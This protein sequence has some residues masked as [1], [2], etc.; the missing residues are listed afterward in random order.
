[1]KTQFLVPQLIICAFA[2]ASCGGDKDQPAAPVAPNSPS[3]PSNPS[4]P[5]DPHPADPN[6]VAFSSLA[7][8]LSGTWVHKDEC[9]VRVW[10]DGSETSVKERVQIQ[11]TSV[12]VHQDVFLDN[13]CTDL[14]GFGALAGDVDVSRG[15][16]ALRLNPST[17]DLE[18][19]LGMKVTKVEGESMGDVAPG[20]LLDVTFAYDP[21]SKEMS[22]GVP[23]L[24]FNG[25]F[26]RAP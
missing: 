14:A 9:R 5:T 10:E 19:K 2:L 11:G 13:D 21:E 7:D 20:S 16:P 4:T 18:T 1:M 3:N 23:K 25:H 12:S 6:A 22:L 8:E 17:K 26:K 24:K 15:D